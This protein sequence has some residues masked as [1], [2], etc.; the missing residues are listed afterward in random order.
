MK[1]QCKFYRTKWNGTMPNMGENK[2]CVGFGGFGENRVKSVHTPFFRFVDYFFC[3]FQMTRIL[4]NQKR[5]TFF[6][7]CLIAVE[8]ILQTK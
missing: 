8:Y 7:F 6:F 5:F 4:Y 3:L 1:L 2:S